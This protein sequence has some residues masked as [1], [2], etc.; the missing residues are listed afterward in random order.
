MAP[1]APCTSSAWSR[2]GE[3]WR[4][5]ARRSAPTTAP[6]SWCAISR[7]SRS[8]STALRRDFVANVSHELRTPLAAIQGY[9]ETL[10][11]G[12]IDERETALRFSQR[13]VDQCRR[14]AALLADLL[15]R[16]RLEGRE[17]LEPRS[18][19]TCAPSPARRSSW[20]RRRPRPGRSRSSS[21]PVRPRS[22]PAIP[23]DSSPV[24]EP[25][26]ERGQVQPGR[27]P[28]RDHP[29]LPGR[30]AGNSGDGRDRSAR[31]RHRHPRVG[32]AAHLRALLPRR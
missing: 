26:R 20:W 17:A 12:A 15:R 8:S 21:S 25:A 3:R 18:R 22:C 10:S 2:F 19:S 9:A 14:L 6:S 16:S 7:P 28:G 24:L 11:D 29:R 31:H 30:A 1:G 27:R 5:P 23:K 13:I 32:S 4:S